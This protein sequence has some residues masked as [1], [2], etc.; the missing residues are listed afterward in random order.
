MATFDTRGALPGWVQNLCSDSCLSSWRILSFVVCGLLFVVSCC[1]LHPTCTCSCQFTPLTEGRSARDLTQAAP[2]KKNKNC[3][4]LSSFGVVC[5]RG[6]LL[7]FVVVVCCCG[8]LLWFVVVVCCCGLLLWFVVVC[9]CLL[10]LVVGCWVVGCWLLVVGCWLLVVG[11]WLLVVG[12]W[13]L[14]V[15]CWRVVWCF[16]SRIMHL[17]VRDLI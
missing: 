13:L 2:S 9:C 4:R 12:C 5:C 15:G 8:L 7:W 11:C 3:R 10:L 1:Y 16:L 6:L 14:V 17:P